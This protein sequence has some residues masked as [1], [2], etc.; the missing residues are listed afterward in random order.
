M[1]VYPTT[2]EE[3]IPM[4]NNTTAP[5]KSKTPLYLIC[6]ALIVAVVLAIVGFA[7]KSDALKTADELTAKVTE[8][9][10]QTSEAAGQLEAAEAAKAELESSN[11]ALTADLEAAKADA[12]TAKAEVEAAKAEAETAKADAEAAK[13]EVETA[14]AEA[15]AAK[16]EAEAAVAAAAVPAVVAEPAEEPAAE[17]VE[18]DLAGKLV[19]LHTND[20]HGRAVS[21]DDTLGYAR[22][23]ALKKNLQARGADVL[24]FDAG[25][26]SQGT[27]LVNLGY[28]KNAI[29]FMNAAGYDAAS[30]GNHEF[31]WGTDNLLANMENAEFAVLCANLTRTADGTLVFDANKTF[32]TAI[33]KVGVFAL[34]TPETMTK[35][36][37]DKVKGV[38]FAQAEELYAIAQAQVDELKAAGCELIVCVG[39]LGDAD[40][41]ITNRSMDVIANVTGINLFIDGH[42]HTTIDGGVM[43]GETLRTSTGEYSEAIGY[44]VAEKVTKEDATTITL[45]AGLWTVDN[46]TETALIVGSDLP[47]DEEVNAAVNAINDAVE[48]ELS[49]TF[50]KTEVLLDG[51]RAPGVR[52]QETNLGDFSADAILWAAKQAVGD[53]VVAALTNGGG[54]RASIEIGDVTMKTMKTVFPFGNEVAT[55]NVTGAELLEALEAA[56]WST[57]DAIGAFPQVAGIE[58]IIDT[59]VA[60]E[61][62]DMYPNST[63]Y[64]PANPGSRV[65]ITTV[66]GEPWDAEKLYTIA[67]NDFTAAGGDTYYAFAYAFQ[68]TGIKTGVALEDALVNYTQTVLNGVIG[69][70][71]AAPQGRIIIK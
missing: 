46:N 54:I 37:P 41:S 58:Y 17:P 13:A 27:P 26:Y 61:N 19:I 43:E 68:Q 63:Y 47:M 50:A 33:G 66:G 38:T 49:A 6:L 48:A 69:E 56:T 62:G 45:D 21:S 14:K 28:G 9:E 25:D 23:A 52:T 34:D 31:D 30:L 65:T 15:E 32:D 35:A 12:E 59:T 60:Y 67:T 40:E 3:V 2:K 42:S 51:N 20:I 8:L 44:V 4:A 1:I 5:V 36:H 11:A 57:P 70:Q 39:H 53:H 29:A 64:A 16:A 7:G 55:L 18:Q 10:T 22:I 71:Y 24:L